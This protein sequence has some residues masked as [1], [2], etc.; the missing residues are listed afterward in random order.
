[1]RRPATA[2][3]ITGILVQT[4]IPKVTADKLRRK[5][6]SEGLSVA[7]FVRRLLVLHIDGMGPNG[8]AVQATDII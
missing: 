1:M 2:S 7:A 5:A 8:R 4:R 3:S 6:R